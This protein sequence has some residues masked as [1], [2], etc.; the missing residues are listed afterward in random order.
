MEVLQTNFGLR[1]SLI[2][3]GGRNASSR[4]SI[5][6]DLDGTL[7]SVDEKP[8]SAKSTRLEVNVLAEWKDVDVK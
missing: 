1:R 4:S 8:L 7:V 2:V 3:D 6:V 5:P